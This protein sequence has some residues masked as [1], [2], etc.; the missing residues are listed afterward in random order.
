[1]PEHISRTRMPFPRGSDR[2]EQGIISAY[3]PGQPAS[4]L[5]AAYYG[6]V[7][8]DERTYGVPAQ[9]TVGTEPIPGWVITIAPREVFWRTR[10]E[11]EEPGW[12]EDLEGE[13]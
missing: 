8:G 9:V 1:M 6:M 13:W 3:I 4:V 2:G 12:L 5:T 11:R 10:L 7:T